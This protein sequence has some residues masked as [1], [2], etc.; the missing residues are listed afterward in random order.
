ML[1]LESIARALIN[2]FMGNGILDKILQIGQS[3]GKNALMDFLE[4]QKPEVKDQEIWKN[5][6]GMSEPEIETYGQNLAKS[7]GLNKQ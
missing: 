2:M 5:L 1:N 4:N 3:K 6:R 7:F